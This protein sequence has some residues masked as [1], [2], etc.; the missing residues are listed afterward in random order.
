MRNRIAALFRRMGGRNRKIMLIGAGLGVVVAV[1]GPAGIGIGSYYS[2]GYYYSYYQPYCTTAHGPGSSVPLCSTP[3]PK[4]TPTHHV[5]D[6]RTPP[7][8]ESPSPTPTESPTPTPTASD[9]PSPAPSLE[10]A[11]PTPVPSPPPGASGRVTS[12]VR[13]H[14]GPPGAHVR[15][16]GH[17][18]KPDSTV[19]ISFAGHRLGRA[20]T[21]PNGGFNVSRRIPAG[22]KPGSHAFLI[23]GSGPT[24]DRVLRKAW[25]GVLRL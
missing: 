12:T 25:F 14:T 9:E 19:R 18:W 15:L 8:T 24:G 2:V 4:P 11:S 7:P 21:G 3:T 5:D 16:I 22:V 17:G 1:A 23:R 6:D 20:H 10:A 13:P